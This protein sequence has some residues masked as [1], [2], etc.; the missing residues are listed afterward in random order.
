MRPFSRDLAASVERWLA[1]ARKARV[2]VVGDVMLDRYL[3]GTVDRIS[4]EAPVPVLRERRR[5]ALP[6]GAANVAAGIRALGA[7]AR[8]VGAIGDDRAG[9]ALSGALERRGIPADGL[10][11]VPGR[12]TT[13]KIR[14]LAR[15]QQVLRIDREER[16]ALGEG[17]AG[18][19]VSKALGRLPSAHAVVLQDYDKGTLSP[20]VVESV[21]GAARDAHVPIIVDPKLRNFFG[22]AGATVFKPNRAE[23]AAA[24]GRE[25]LPVDGAT[26]RDLAERAGCEHLIVTL[27]PEGLCLLVRG[28][29][30]PVVLPS[31]AREV[32]DVSGAG[33]TVT[34]ALAVG[35]AAGIEVEA[36]ARL[37][38]LAAGIAVSKLGARPVGRRA[39]RAAVR[40]E[41]GR[42]EPSARS[43][44]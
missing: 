36:A 42:G 43:E 40:P 11:S 32:Y 9:R 18:E 30:R 33:D 13:T 1:D 35:L 44:E 25:D 4:P 23:A 17:A 15:H 26:L 12:P 5:L 2:L 21:L 19:V 38:N 8:L 31:R 20:P 27:G 41:S 37:A 16:A 10:V 6:G 14:L 24:L 34:A 22:Y 39:V 3:S 7:E 29:E 28:S